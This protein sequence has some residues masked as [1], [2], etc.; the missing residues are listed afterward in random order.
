MKIVEEDK[1]NRVHK[2]EGE[3]YKKILKGCERIRNGFEK[4]S[5]A[6]Y[7]YVNS[8]FE[9]KITYLNCRSNRQDQNYLFIN[10]PNP[11]GLRER[12]K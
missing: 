6:K 3:P 11:N 4:F 2:I 1:R 9:F 12:W 10:N 7:S 5:R 8:K